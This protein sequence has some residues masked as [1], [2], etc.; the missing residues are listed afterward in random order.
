MRIGEFEEKT[1]EWSKQIDDVLVE[2]IGL[3]DAKD[4]RFTVDHAPVAEAF[5]KLIYQTRV[6]LMTSERSLRMED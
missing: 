4:M 3:K 1:K 6:T 5:A 2:I